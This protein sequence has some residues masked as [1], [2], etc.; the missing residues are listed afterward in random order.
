[1]G[2]FGPSGRGP[3]GRRS[4][5][6]PIIPRMAAPDADRAPAKAEAGEAVERLVAVMA[7]LRSED[8]CPWDRKQTWESLRRYVLEEAHE[9]A[10]A[11]DEGDED[12]VREECGDLLLEVVFLAQ[13]ASEEGRFGM[14]EVAAGIT[15]K[16]VRRHPQVFRDSRRAADADEALAT[17]EAVKA[18]EKRERGPRSGPEFPVTLPALVAAAKVAEREAAP[19]DRPPEAAL[20]AL[21]RSEA[22]AHRGG[23]GKGEREE[24]AAALG[25]AL[26]DLARRAAAAGVDP[27]AALLAAVRRRR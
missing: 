16:L 26:Y 24:F 15:E 12:A 8:G 20:A 1:M 18:Q 5:R 4:S 27:E 14:A 17:W 21:G 19:A 3:E 2:N 7:R 22:D 11:I 10:A 6:G 23:A 9:L 25:E 13:I